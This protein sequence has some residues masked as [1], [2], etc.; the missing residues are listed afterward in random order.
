MNE[1]DRSNRQ[2]IVNNDIS[3]NSYIKDSK[4]VR[5]CQILTETL[6]TYWYM[7]VRKGSEDKNRLREGES[8]WLPAASISKLVSFWC[9]AHFRRK[10]STD[11]WTRQTIHIPS[12]CKP[13]LNRYWFKK[14]LCS[15]SLEIVVAFFLGWTTGGLGASSGNK[16][17]YTWPVLLVG[18]AKFN[19]FCR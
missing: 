6:E 16:A 17:W 14:Q 13:I 12:G 19:L 3:P 4:L 11:S 18:M 15:L 9:F 7:M 2:R 8:P 5:A 1:G 10:C